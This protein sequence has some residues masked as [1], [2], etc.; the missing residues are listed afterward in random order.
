MRAQQAITWWCHDMKKLSTLLALCKGNHH[1]LVVPFTKGWQC[2]KCFHTKT[3]MDGFNVFFVV[4]IN[5]LLNKQS[6]LQWF[7]MPW[8]SCYITVM[9]NSERWYLRSELRSQFLQ[10]HYSSKNYKN[11][12]YLL[13]IKFMFDSCY[14]ILATITSTNY[15]C[16]SIHLTGASDGIEVPQSLVC[17]SVS[18][19]T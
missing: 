16:D 5:K 14:N 19:V 12:G 11:M 13:N 7:E 9:D 17:P 8:G 3:I 1:S 10:I 15:E 18:E 2:G 6:S 4:S